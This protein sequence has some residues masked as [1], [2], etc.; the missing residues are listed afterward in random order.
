M[1]TFNHSNFAIDERIDRL[2]T[3]NFETVVSQTMETSTF[4]KDIEDSNEKREVAIQTVFRHKEQHKLK[5]KLRAAKIKTKNSGRIRKVK[6]STR[7]WKKGNISLLRTCLVEM[8]EKRIDQEEKRK[9][10]TDENRG[11]FEVLGLVQKR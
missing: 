1:A 4:C 8:Y 9:V 7:K 6:S 11:L 5:E 2:I 3:S 10:E